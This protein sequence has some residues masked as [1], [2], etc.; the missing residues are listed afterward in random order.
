[1]IGGG[2]HKNKVEVALQAGADHVIVDRRGNFAREVLHLTDGQGVDLVCN[3][4]GP[5]AFDGLITSLSRSGTF[6]W[7]GQVLGGQ[8][9]LDIM[10]LPKSINIG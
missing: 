8:D 6:C 7:Y 3:R 2:S 9:A 5:V 10:A 1:M 4:S